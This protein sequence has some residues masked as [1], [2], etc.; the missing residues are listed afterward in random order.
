MLT[1][2][3]NELFQTN[4]TASVSNSIDPDQ[5]RQSVYICISQSV[6]PDLGSNCFEMMTRVAASKERGNP[7]FFYQCSDAFILNMEFTFEYRIYF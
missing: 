5:D 2:F 4:L 1:F 6:S 3:Q 7:K